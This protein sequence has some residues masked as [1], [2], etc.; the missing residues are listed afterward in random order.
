MSSPVDGYQSRPSRSW[1]TSFTL[2][3]TI[4]RSPLSCAGAGSKT[5]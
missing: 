5:L 3:G 2:I 4:R 1:P